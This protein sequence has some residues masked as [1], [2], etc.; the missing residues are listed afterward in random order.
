MSALSISSISSTGRS[1]RREGLPQLAALD[2]VADVV[3]ARVAELAVAQA[4]DGVVLVEALLRLGGRLDVPLDERRAE[5]LGDFE[6]QHR[7]AGAGL[8]LDQ[9][10]PLQRDGGVDGDLQIVGRDVA[11]GA[12][13]LHRGWR[14]SWGRS[15]SGWS[16]GGAGRE[17][18]KWAPRSAAPR[19]ASH[20]RAHFR[21][22]SE[23]LPPDRGAHFL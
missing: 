6:R 2:V 20:S 15:K 9:Q 14:G 5:R 10:G 19:D 13:E 1:S 11:L 7:L 12:L 3:D 8:A 22:K 21:Q 18:C 16:L 23:R 17:S 4:R